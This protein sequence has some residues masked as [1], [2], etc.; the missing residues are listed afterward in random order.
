[1]WLP[2]SL[3]L[4]SSVLYICHCCSFHLNFRIPSINILTHTCSF[5]GIV[6]LE[7]EYGTLHIKVSDHAFGRFVFQMPLTSQLWCAP[8]MELIYFF[9]FFNFMH[10]FK[11]QSLDWKLL[12][13]ALPRLCS[14][15][16][17]LHSWVA[18][19]AS[20]CWLPISSCR[21]PRSIVGCRREPHKKGKLC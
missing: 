7:T 13:A 21:G 2:L 9:R 8:L 10:L 18:H 15:F 17:S 5:Q 11:S 6:G 4:I 16:C 19:S 12:G 3:L 1:M 20:L 14:P